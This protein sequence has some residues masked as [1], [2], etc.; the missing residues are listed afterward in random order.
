MIQR[1]EALSSSHADQWKKAMQEEYDS[2]LQNK[3]WSLVDL[4]SDKRALPCKW[5]FK[6]KTNEKGEVHTL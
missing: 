1:Q 2:L 3:T 6:T 5:V 4:P